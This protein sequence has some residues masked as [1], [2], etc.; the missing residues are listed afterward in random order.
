M[1]G[2]AVIENFLSDNES[3]ELKAAGLEL[4]QSAPETDR[5]VFDTKNPKQ[6]KEVDYH[7]FT[8]TKGFPK[9]N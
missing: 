1:N 6:C 7:K 4:C 3:N 2:F 5:K 8:M 9:F